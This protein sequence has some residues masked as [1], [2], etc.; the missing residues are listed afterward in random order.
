MTME[1]KLKIS[2]LYSIIRDK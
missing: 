2:S 1:R